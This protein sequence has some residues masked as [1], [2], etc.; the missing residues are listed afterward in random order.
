MFKSN[1]IISYI[2][3]LLLNRSKCKWLSWL[4]ITMSIKKNK[5]SK[6]CRNNRS[7]ILLIFFTQFFFL[8]ISYIGR[9]IIRSYVRAY[10]SVKKEIAR[11][12]T[13]FDCNFRR[14]CVIKSSRIYLNVWMPHSTI[15]LFTFHDVKQCQNIGVYCAIESIEMHRKKRYRATLAFFKEIFSMIFDIQTIN[16]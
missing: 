4:V 10:L 1:E 12:P 9:L 8:F 16:R 7:K 2:H 14:I 6:K 13:H 3:L 5:E 15:T 11:Y